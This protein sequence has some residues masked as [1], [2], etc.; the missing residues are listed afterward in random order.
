MI[1]YAYQI[2]LARGVGATQLLEGFQ[3]LEGLLGLTYINQHTSVEI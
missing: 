1:E 3:R 2:T